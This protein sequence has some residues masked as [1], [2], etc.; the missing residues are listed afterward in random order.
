M[1]KILALGN[2]LLS[3]DGI[4]LYLAD[5]LEPKVMKL[6]YKVYKCETDTSYAISVL[7]EKDD[8]IIIDASFTGRD[9]GAISLL[10]LDE[11]KSEYYTSEKFCHS[12]TVFDYIFNT[13]KIFK[14]YVIL[15]E[16]CSMELDN[17]L[18][19]VIQHK[20]YQIAENVYKL[21]EKIDN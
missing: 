20:F 11:Y 16:V 3:D 5:Y 2:I 6:G 19:T 1:K 14:G 15:V 21:I 7:N 10:N 17:R 4:A 12:N 8:L 9:S 13:D 18:S